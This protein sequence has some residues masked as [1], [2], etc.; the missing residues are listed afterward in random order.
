VN[1]APGAFVAP[2]WEPFSVLAFTVTGGKIVEIDVFA[3]PERI[4]QLDLADLLTDAPDRV[5]R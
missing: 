1:G 4:R 2:H 5:D 3:D